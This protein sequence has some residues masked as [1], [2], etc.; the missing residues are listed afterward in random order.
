MRLPP[1]VL[2]RRYGRI[3]I[4]GMW[5]I[6]SKWAKCLTARLLWSRANVPYELEVYHK[7]TMSDKQLLWKHQSAPK[8]SFVGVRSVCA[9]THF[10]FCINLHLKSCCGA[11]Y[12][13]IPGYF[14]FFLL[15]LKAWLQLPPQRL[16]FVLHKLCSRLLLSLG[17]LNCERQPQFQKHFQPTEQR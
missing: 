12:T 9:R 5:P 6:R 1:S 10:V 8:T 14:F 3:T 2:T 4:L 7:S 13:S 16:P 11:K 15:R 17:E